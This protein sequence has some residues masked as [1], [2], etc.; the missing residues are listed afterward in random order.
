MTE[1]IW[2]TEELLNELI[3]IWNKEE[4]DESFIM[5]RILTKTNT[6][7]LLNTKLELSND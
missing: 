4:H 5:T 3:N 1:K 7:E 6:A 2:E